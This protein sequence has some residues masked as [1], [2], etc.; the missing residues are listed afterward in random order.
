MDLQLQCVRQFGVS[1]RFTDQLYAD[2]LVV[3]AECQHEL[4]VALDAGPTKSAVMVFG[5]RR[6]VPPC[7]AFL[8]GQ[9]LP[10]VSE[11]PYLGVI[12][13]PSL[14]WTAHARHLVSRGNRLF[15]Q[16]VAW[17][18]SERLPLRF[19]STLFMSYVLP[20]ISWG[21]EFLVSS[22]PALQVIDT[23]L[24][25]WG[26]FSLGMACRFS[27]RFCFLGIGMA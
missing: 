21:V 17:C 11:Y 9:E 15:A 7:S 1:H 14:S 5:P 19:A 27:Q 2:D 26:R 3:T 12:L 23:A 16:C 8:S 24:R 22:P 13:T 20:S 4:Q 10:L 18:K 25:R 6:S